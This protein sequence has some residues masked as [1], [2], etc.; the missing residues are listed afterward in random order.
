MNL[1]VI[2]KV[3]LLVSCLV[4]TE[5]QREYVYTLNATF[6]IDVFIPYYSQYTMVSNQL[7]CLGKKEVVVMRRA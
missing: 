2:A 3:A 4:F 7:S 6:K 5:A 1:L